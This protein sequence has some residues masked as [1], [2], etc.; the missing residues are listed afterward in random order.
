MRLVRQEPLDENDEIAEA[1]WLPCR[2][3]M[4]RM[5]YESERELVARLFAMQSK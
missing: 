1:V 3:A 5:T 2:Q 4:A